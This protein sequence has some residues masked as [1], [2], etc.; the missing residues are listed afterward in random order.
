VFPQFRAFG[1]LFVL[2]GGSFYVAKRIVNTR[3]S[4]EWENVRAQ[5]RK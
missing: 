2:F 5:Q 1:G 3:K 4:N